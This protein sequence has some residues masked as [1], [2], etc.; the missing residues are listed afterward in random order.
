MFFVQRRFIIE[1]DIHINSH[2]KSDLEN[3]KIT[4][5][6]VNGG[7]S[8]TFELWQMGNIFYSETEEINEDE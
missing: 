7:L 2:F 6:P 8:K 3:L 1:R 4:V 5:T